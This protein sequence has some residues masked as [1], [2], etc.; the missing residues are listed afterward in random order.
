MQVQL[1][2]GA[3]NTLNFGTGDPKRPG[4]LYIPVPLARVR[5]MI[6]YLSRDKT[7]YFIEGKGGLVVPTEQQDKIPQGA[8][9]IPDPGKRMT[10]V[11]EAHVTVSMGPELEKALA[12]DP[13]G[14]LVRAGLFSQTG[15]GVSCPVE[16]TGTL[17][18]LQ[19]G[20]YKDEY[21]PKGPIL[22]AEEVRVPKLTAVR[23][24]LGLAELPTLPGGQ[25]YIPHITYGYI[26]EKNL[27]HATYVQQ[28]GSRPR[29]RGL[30]TD[31]STQGQP[32]P[33]TQ[34]ARLG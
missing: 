34:L 23:K 19:A 28:H 7:A 9:V 30:P 32:T 20:F 21:D 13:R 17:R 29:R 14:T 25:P 11:G 8:L 26:A 22:V 33:D 15:E 18:V 16:F 27:I 12:G 5:A 1:G 10:H 31:P 6:R 2:T 3:D 24:A 4:F